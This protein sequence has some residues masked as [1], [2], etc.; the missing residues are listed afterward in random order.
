MRL[1]RVGP[2]VELTRAVDAMWRKLV[3][4]QVLTALPMLLQQEGQS[5]LQ[6]QVEYV[7][8]QKPVLV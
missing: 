4:A 3:L 1:R 5:A 6:T 2:S 7:M 8:W